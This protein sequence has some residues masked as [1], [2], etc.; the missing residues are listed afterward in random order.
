MLAILSSVR[1]YFMVVLAS[2]NI[3]LYMFNAFSILSKCL[4][5]PYGCK[6][7]AEMQQQNQHGF[8]LPSSQFH[9][10]FA[11]NVDLSNLGV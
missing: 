6:F 10:R 1:W 2:Q 4:V 5:M 9:D 11:L 3:L 8:L 7:A